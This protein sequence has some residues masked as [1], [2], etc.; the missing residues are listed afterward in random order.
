MISSN[1]KRLIL[2][3]AILAGPASLNALSDYYFSVSYTGTIGSGNQVSASGG[4]GVLAVGWNNYIS[5]YASNA[6]AVGSNLYVGAS[7]SLVVGA[8]NIPTSSAAFVVGNGTGSD[9]L[10]NNAMEVLTNGTVNIPGT[11]NIGKVPQRGGISMG[12]FTTP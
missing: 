3:A 8:Y 12:D 4:S 2:A 1:S 9:T 5:Y 7:N 10:R 11:A 6:A